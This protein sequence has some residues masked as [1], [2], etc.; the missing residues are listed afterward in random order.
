MAT[1]RA[2]YEFDL[3]DLNF[4][5]INEASYG[6]RLG[7]GVDSE[8]FG[9]TYEDIYA[10]YWESYPFQTHIMG[11][12][13][14]DMSTNPAG[15]IVAGRVQ[16]IVN[17]VRAGAVQLDDWYVIGTD[18]AARDLTT[19]GRTRSTADDKKVV[20]E[21]F[22]GND[23]FQLSHGDDYIDG[24]AGNDVV[25]AGLGDDS[26]I[27]GAGN[28]RLYGQNGDD[29]L[30]L[31]SGNDRLD[32]GAGRDWVYATGSTRIV[33]DLAK[34]VAQNTGYGQ[35]VL[36]RIENVQAASGNDRISGSA[37]YN[38]LSGMAGDD[39]LVG[40]AGNDTLNGGAGDDTLDGGQGRDRLQ[41]GSGED[42][43]V[44]RSL[45]EVSDNGKSADRIT[46]FT[47]GQDHIH[48][49]GID[50]RENTANNNRFVFG[51]EVSTS[52]VAEG[53]V[54]YRKFDVAD[55]SR[56]FTAVLFGTDADTKAEG[57]IIL[58][59]LVD[60]TAGDFIL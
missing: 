14:E 20:A 46:D 9:K 38:E 45:D 11:Y 22:K 16:V 42:L 52:A 43:F 36:V 48:L 28:D 55:D 10:Y 51:G 37:R 44:F 33:V 8:L 7:R 30:Y 3:R 12:M 35:D 41:G 2:H 21:I 60:L 57:V 40:R 56:D 34:T 53:R 31:D 24:H 5:D 54:V 32:G 58:V 39:R 27:G 23:R 29:R 26:V 15:E 50:A 49:Y 1:F 13:G 17:T 47:R 25:T 19:A 59:G 18:I 6:A 4:F